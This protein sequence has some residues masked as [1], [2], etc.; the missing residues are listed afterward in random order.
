MGT[1]PP[2]LPFNYR[3]VLDFATR[4]SQGKT[5]PAIL[6]YGC[7]SGQVVIAGRQMGMNIYGAEVFHMGD[8]VRDQVATA[9][10]LGTTIR[11]IKAGVI[12]FPDEYFDILFSNQV[13]EHVRDFDHVLDEIQRVMKPGGIAL[14]L[15]PSRDV[16]REG[17]CGIPFLHWFLKKS[18]LRYPYAY[19]MRSLGFGNFK[20]PDKRTWTLNFLNYLDNYCFYRSRASIFASF[21]KYFDIKMIEDDYVHARLELSRLRRLAPLISWPLVRPLAMESFRKLGG[22]VILSSKRTPIF[23]TQY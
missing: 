5:Q 18:A 2:H 8:R 7:G 4:L 14:H 17:H 9:G 3:Y 13:M 10:L 11:E 19:A 20:T 21:H 22:M 6:D 1:L 15:F 16:W 23:K 12:D